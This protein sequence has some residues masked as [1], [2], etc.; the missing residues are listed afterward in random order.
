MTPEQILRGL[1]HY[2]RALDLVAKY[3]S[4]TAAIELFNPPR[5]RGFYF[6]LWEENDGSWLLKFSNEHAVRLADWE[7]A[8]VLYKA[9]AG[10][11]QIRKEC[12][13]SIEKIKE[14]P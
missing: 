1:E 7:G 11:A 14:T 9:E 13:E 8:G 4:L 3:E 6:S 2:R 12:R 5:S 10:I